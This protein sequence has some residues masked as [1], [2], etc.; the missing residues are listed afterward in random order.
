[1]DYNDMLRQAYYDCIVSLNSFQ[2][3]SLGAGSQ[4]VNVSTFDAKVAWERFDGC[5]EILLA[6]ITEDQKDATFKQNLQPGK[7]KLT[8]IRKIAADFWSTHGS[9]KTEEYE[10]EETR[11]KN[12]LEVFHEI[13]ELFKRTGLW[14][15]KSAFMGRL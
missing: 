10:A 4:G 15:I 5:V 14:H 8:K 3:E 13:T 7:V 12:S 6:M 1:M 9:Q 2:A 11:A